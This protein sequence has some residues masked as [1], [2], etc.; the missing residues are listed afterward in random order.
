M[1]ILPLQVAQCALASSDASPL[2]LTKPT[3]NLPELMQSK[4]V[5]PTVPSYTNSFLGKENMYSFN[6]RRPKRI[7]LKKEYDIVHPS[8]VTR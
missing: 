8:Y 4:N 3:S 6:D 5:T 2:C 7:S 1:T